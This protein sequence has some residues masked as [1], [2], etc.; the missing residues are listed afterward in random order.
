MYDQ[1]Y[2]NALI[3]QTR[4]ARKEESI[5]DVS[6]DIQKGKRY[7]INSLLIQ[8]KQS[9]PEIIGD[10]KH[11]LH[12]KLINKK[13]SS[14]LISKVIT[15]I[16]KQLLY[17]GFFQSE[18]SY[19]ITQDD[20]RATVTILFSIIF[21]AQKKYLFRGNAYLS[22]EQIFETVF[23]GQSFWLLPEAVLQKEIEDVYRQH[24]FWDI[25]IS[26][27][28]IENGIMFT[29]SEGERACI[30]KVIINGT[31][32][33][34]SNQLIS[35]YFSRLLKSRFFDE[36]L[37]D[38]ALEKM[39]FF[40][41]SHGYWDTTI[42]AKEYNKSKNGRYTL[43]LTIDEGS[44]Y[45]L[46]QV[47]IWDFPKL[48]KTWPFAIGKK[49]IPFNKAILY[50][51]YYWLNN[52]FNDHGYC[53]IKTHPEMQE[54]K[55]YHYRVIW[56]IER[57]KEQSKFGKTTIIKT[58]KLPIAF[59]DRELAYKSQETWNTKKLDQSIA[60][61]RDL[62][63]FK[64]V[65]YS[66]KPTDDKKKDLIIT[67][68]EDDPFELRARLGL[69]QVS[70][71]KSFDT[72]T[73]FK[74]GGSF[75]WKNPLN[76]AGQFLF[77]G[78]I[79]RFDRNV[80]A[81]YSVP[82]IFGQR[83]A[84]NARIYSN[85]QNNPPFIEV[86]S[87]L[88]ETK[89]DGIGIDFQ[90]DL[91]VVSWGLSTGFEWQGVFEGCDIDCDIAQALDFDAELFNRRFLY[92]YFSPHCAIRWLDD[93]LDPHKGFITSVFVKGMVNHEDKERLSFAKILVEQSLF[94]PIVGPVVLAVRFR[95]GHITSQDFRCILP[96]ER[97]F[98]GG[99]NT[100]RGYEPDFVPPLGECV[101]DDCSICIPQ[102]GKTMVNANFE[103]RFPIY[104][105]MH[106]VIFNDLGFLCKNDCFP[107]RPLGATGLGLRAKSPL[108][109]LRFDVGWKWK[110]DGQT[111]LAWYLTI[112]H[113][114]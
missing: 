10:L 36:T 113:A 98:L 69:Q 32:R 6:I 21:N 82:W 88:Y 58:G 46:D 54:C 106:G 87:K 13:F 42:L 16:K 101:Q 114:F 112:G 108:G 75:I 43:T 38:D 91:G 72:G 37:L 99:P 56:H 41:V 90:K 48:S 57:E 53:I 70:K 84:M 2:L 61:L 86:D 100:V 34:S 33:Y 73:S 14:Q 3:S 67:V 55:S 109:I 102:G 25:A 18:V 19:T 24:G 76:Q 22:T 77:D 15:K 59:I 105:W 28:Y 79:T 20:S 9:D 89:R 96:S 26:S 47:C 111:R 1:G 44:Q 64:T 23:A 29:I 78:D 94:M 93:E 52:Y 110:L 49:P 65:Q 11:N 63:I 97:F 5:V 60:R 107:D 4:R 81:Q 35:S 27:E 7:K 74:A 92:F 95:F 80:L 40:Y 45:F 85:R 62:G 30:K 39:I 68:A 103:F 50:E 51:Q 83:I 8:S 104:R 12:K 31:Q 71:N 17:K 66:I